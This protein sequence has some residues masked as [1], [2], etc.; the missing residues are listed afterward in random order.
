MSR[1]LRLTSTTAKRW[2]FARDWCWPSSRSCRS[3]PI[4]WLTPT[5]GRCARRTGAWLLSLSTQSWSQK[6]ASGSDC[7]R[8]SRNRLGTQPRHRT[9]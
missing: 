9:R 2:F 5:D 8:V 6:K 1:L 7:L 3:L 4:E